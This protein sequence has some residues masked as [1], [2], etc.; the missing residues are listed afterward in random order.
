MSAP[1]AMVTLFSS[2][3]TRVPN[4]SI[5][6]I[7]AM[8]ALLYRFPLLLFILLLFQSVCIALLMLKMLIK[9][10]LDLLL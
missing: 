2:V 1:V 6:F 3:V 8:P 5:F 4:F 10:H 9:S 7:M